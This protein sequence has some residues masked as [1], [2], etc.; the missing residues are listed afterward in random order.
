MSTAT[1]CK[2][3][4]L[5]Y[6]PGSCTQSKYESLHHMQHKLEWIL[7]HKDEIDGRQYNE[8]MCYESCSHCS[9]VYSQRGKLLGWVTHTHNTLSQQ[10]ADTNGS[11]PAIQDSNLH[12]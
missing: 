6:Q 8:S 12:Q 11:K 5:F 1:T 9:H 4:F 10:K 3:P 2:M 7:A